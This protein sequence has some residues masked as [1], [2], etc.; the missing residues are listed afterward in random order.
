M[1]SNYKV[2]PFVPS[3][4]HKKGTSSDAAI[5]LESLIARHVNEG[6]EY[7]RLESVTTWVSADEGCFGFNAKPGYNTTAQMVVFK[8]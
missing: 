1:S 2:V 4:D 8:K 7:V 5:Q 6:Y 3:I